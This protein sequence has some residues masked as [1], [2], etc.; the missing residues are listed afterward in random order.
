VIHVNG[1]HRSEYGGEI[2][3]AQPQR[4]LFVLPITKSGLSANKGVRDAR[5]TGH[6]QRKPMEDRTFYSADYEFNM[7]RMFCQHVLN[8]LQPDHIASMSCTLP[9]HLSPVRRP[10][11]SFSC[12]VP[13]V[14]IL[15]HGSRRPPCFSTNTLINPLRQKWKDV[16][17]FYALRVPISAPEFPYN[18]GF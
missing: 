13:P 2:K 4:S 17:S 8:A 10:G 14:F 15:Q 18:Q 12:V 16:R 6:R 5:A 9:S 11:G 3:T 7:P 1:S